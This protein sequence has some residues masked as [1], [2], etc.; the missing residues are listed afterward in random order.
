[1]GFVPTPEAVAEYKI[2]NSNYDAQY[3]RTAGGTMTVSVKDGTNA[4]HGA[5]YWLNKNTVL[6]ANS[7]DAN[8]PATT[9]AAYHENN[10]G[11]E[12]DGPVF[13]PH[14]YNGKNKTF[15]MWSYEI[16]RDAIPTPTT[17]TLPY[18]AAVA[19][20]FNTTLQSNGRRSRSTTP[21][22]PR[23]RGRPICASH[24]PATLFRRTA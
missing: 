16:W 12:F 19:G 4:F 21:T 23:H 2:Q 5:L 17:Q 8:R 11:L 9:R 18:P 24:F 15:F 1:M 3:G 14:V 6:T 13:I 7:F 20:N 10:P 22:P